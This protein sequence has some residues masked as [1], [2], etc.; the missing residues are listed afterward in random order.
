MELTLEET[1]FKNFIIERSF[2]SSSLLCNNQI[3]SCK[4]DNIKIPS[5]SDSDNSSNTSDISLSVYHWSK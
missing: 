5:Q 2:T 1:R 3:F 4:S